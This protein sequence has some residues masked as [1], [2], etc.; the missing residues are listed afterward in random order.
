MV[1]SYLND[2]EC[3]IPLWFALDLNDRIKLVKTQ[4]NRE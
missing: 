2:G 4:A 1:E 3:W